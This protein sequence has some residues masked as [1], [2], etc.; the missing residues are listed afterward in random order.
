MA[1]PG[2]STNLPIN[3]IEET[4]EYFATIFD[5]RIDVSQNV[6]DAL[7][8]FFIARTENKDTALALVHTVIVT[9]VGAKINPM[10]ILDTFRATASDGFKLD[11][12]LATFLNKT[13]NNTSMLGVKNVP[14]V[15]KQ[16]ARTI[17]S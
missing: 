9:A 1:T 7:Y 5:T 3:N 17:L 13:R 16:I 11:A 4:L 8:A 2:P 12:Q 15:N 14:L 10:L 6:V